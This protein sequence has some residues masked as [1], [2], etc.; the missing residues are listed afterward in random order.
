MP[1]KE[2]LRFNC[3]NHVAGGKDW[4]GGS[5]GFFLLAFISF[6]LPLFLFFTLSPLTDRIKRSDV[7]VCFGLGTFL[8]FSV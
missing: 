6:F 3:A 8:G 5:R 4:G 7:P 2:L 1:R